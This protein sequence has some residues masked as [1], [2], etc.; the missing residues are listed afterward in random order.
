MLFRSCSVIALSG[1]AVRSVFSCRQ[2]QA[3]YLPFHRY[4]QDRR[5]VY[6]LD[7]KP[8]TRRDKGSGMDLLRVY[9]VC[10]HSTGIHE[11]R[12]H[13]CLSEER[14]FRSLF[15]KPVLG[16]PADRGTGRPFLR[17]LCAAYRT[18]SGYG[19]DRRPPAGA[20]I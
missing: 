5:D 14:H 12:R 4:Q 11:Y 8:C 7:P 15:G 17:G 6:L 19:H 1:D 20:G 16:E 10:C 13:T 18:V 2:R 9:D 3:G